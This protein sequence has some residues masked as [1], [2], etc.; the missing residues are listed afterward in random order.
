MRYRPF[1]RSGKV[2]SAISLL[3]RESGAVS[4]PAAWRATAIAGLENGINYFELSASGEAL[5]IG[6]GAA[7]STL[8]RRLVLLGWRIQH[9]GRVPLTGRSLMD[10]IQGGLAR[11]GAGYF[12]TLMLDDNAFNCLNRDGH[13][14]LED[15]KAAGLCKRIGI[16]GEGDV[17]DRCLVAGAFDVLSTSCDVT[18]DGQVRRRLREAAHQDIIVVAR[19]PIPTDLIRGS[20]LSL[21]RK[22]G[23]FFGLKPR[24]TLAG[25]GTFQFLHTTPDWTPEDI[26]LAYL[27]TEPTMATV[28]IE[29]HKPDIIADWASVADRELPTGVPAQVEMARFAEEDQPRRRA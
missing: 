18:S 13:Q 24:D 5:P 6:V 12:D 10:N 27:L 9:Q 16:V 26:C 17:V 7:I 3:L 29:A 8:E 19:N 14:C 11:T 4:S 2:V 20:Q 15:L 25:V 22:A 23:S 21:G 28:M 1:G